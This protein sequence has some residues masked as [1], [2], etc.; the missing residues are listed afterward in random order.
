MRHL[1]FDERRDELSRDDAAERRQRLLPLG[2]R[3]QTPQL[4][5]TYGPAEKWARGEQGL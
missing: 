1:L 2:I 5:E 4:I 3:Q